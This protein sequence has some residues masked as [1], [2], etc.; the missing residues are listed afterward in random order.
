MDE[1]EHAHSLCVQNPPNRHNPPLAE[2]TAPAFAVTISL[3][4]YS[5]GPVSVTLMALALHNKCLCSSR[6]FVAF[7]HSG[8][9]I[10]LLEQRDAP[11]SVT[12]LSPGPT[13][14]YCRGLTR[15]HGFYPLPAP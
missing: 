8:T 12:A 7:A 4:R 13:R 6:R 1:D 9:R 2:G 3:L 14:I 10:P 15:L 11:G 5:S